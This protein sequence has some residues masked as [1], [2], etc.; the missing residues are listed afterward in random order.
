MNETTRT[1]ETTEAIEIRETIDFGALCD[2]NLHL[3]AFLGDKF[4]YLVKDPHG[5]PWVIQEA[6]ASQFP[7]M[8]FKL[9]ADGPFSASN[10]L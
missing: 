7:A 8:V 9:L 6:L 4:C 10:R 1:T 3:A 5:P 2:G